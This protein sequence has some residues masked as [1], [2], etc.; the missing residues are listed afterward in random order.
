MIRGL[1]F[2]GQARSCIG[3]SPAKAARAIVAAGA[4]VVLSHCIVQYSEPLSSQ[5]ISVPANGSV[6]TSMI[7][8]ALSGNTV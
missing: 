4:T 2:H 6:A 1:V 3:C 5:L 8:A 7:D